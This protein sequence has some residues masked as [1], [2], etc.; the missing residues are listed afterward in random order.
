MSTPAPRL[1]VTSARLADPADLA[2]LPAL[3]RAGDARFAALTG[4]DRWPD[5]P[6]S[7][8]RAA[9]GGWI[10]V[11]GQPPVG[12][13]HVLDLDGELHLEQLSVLPARGRQG[14]GA[15]LLAAAYGLALDAGATRLV[16]RA[17]ADVPWN[18]PW[19]AAHGFV[20]LPEPPAAHARSIVRERQL[21]LLQ[22]HHAHPVLGPRVSLARPLVD[23]PTPIDAVSVIPVRDGPDGIE[24]FVQHRVATMDFAAGALVFPGGRVDAGDLAAGARLVL[25]RG[26][27]A[28]H[29]RRWRHT[30]SVRWAAA[31]A[32]QPTGSA[33]AEGAPAARTDQV[34]ARTVLATG[35]REVA[36]ETGAHIDPA[37][38][39]PWDD[40][41]TPVGNPRRFDVRFLLHP[42]D[43]GEQAAYGHTTSEAH[44]SEWLPLAAVVRATEAGEV[45]LLPP[46]R[47]LVDELAALGTVAAALDLRPDITTV[48]HDLAAPRPRPPGDR[49]A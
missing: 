18:G 19:Y 33:A 47:A 10:I 23:G 4:A 39:V 46:T 26:L 17:F 38:L 32:G 43:P 8:A 20:E 9:L 44:R 31:D 21:G 30:G 41:V 49:R 11:V 28:A 13:A 45:A 40:W 22:L 3:E 14:I 12:F 25:P 16:L 5:P 27:A 1:S 6:D 2:L 15:M 37:R 34:S 36:E 48:R 35:V 7:L 42:A 24:G 29:A